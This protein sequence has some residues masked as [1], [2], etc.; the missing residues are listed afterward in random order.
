MTACA[1][2]GSIAI[3]VMEGLSE[4]VEMFP[5]SNAMVEFVKAFIDE[6]LGNVVGI[7]YWYAFSSV[8]S[9]L[10]ISAATLTEYWNTSQGLQIGLV[11]VLAPL[12]MLAIN[13][14]GVKY[15]G[16]VECVAGVIKFT[17]VVAGILMLFT[18]A[19]FVGSHNIDDGYQNGIGEGTSPGTA[20]CVILPILAYGFI[21]VEIVS[22]TAFEAS[23]RRSLRY[24]SKMIAYIIAATYFCASLGESIDIAWNNAKLPVPSLR[25]GLAKGL[26]PPT[27]SPEQTQ[28]RTSSALLLAITEQGVE[29]IPG[30]FNGFMIFCIM[31]ASNTGLYVSSR[32]LFGLCRGLNG[33]SDN[34][35]VYWLAKLGES[36]KRTKVPALALMASA[37]AFYWLPFVHL[38]N[39]GSAQNLVEIMATT[40]SIGVFM[41]WVSQCVAFL[42][43]RKWCMM[44]QE[45]LK[46]RYLKYD[47]WTTGDQE[48]E[49]RPTSLLNR[50]QPYVAY[51]GLVGSLSIVL[52]LNTA[53]WWSTPVTAKKVATAYAGPFAMLCLWIF[54]K[55]VNRKG[56]LKITVK[57]DDDWLVLKQTIDRLEHLI[58][59]GDNALEDDRKNT[60]PDQMPDLVADE[61]AEERGGRRFS[62]TWAGHEI[63]F[64]PKTNGPQLTDTSI[65]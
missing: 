8:F 11:Y 49:P 56:N 65:G 21:G 46:G 37:L 55:I 25:S 9:T 33:N 34:P 48:S 20:L 5:I 18:I 1:I 53:Q 52:V 4:M 39:S 51:L 3:F 22:V 31:S 63:N 58:N 14:C 2:L 23:D 24:P 36:T 43:Y 44:H 38:T 54:L 13:F 64:G 7:A 59:E 10:L 15:F 47:R 60:R 29:H 19:P 45:R 27:T 12:G 62:V 40:G 50:F 35:V 57:L 26:T 61:K 6:E 28:H 42:R 30:V 41:V 32:S 17:F 16:Y